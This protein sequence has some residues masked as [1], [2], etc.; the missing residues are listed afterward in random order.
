MPPLN[1]ALALAQADHV[2][3]LVRQYL[4]LDVARALDELLHVEIAVAECRRRL[5]LRRLEHV[6]QL[7]LR[8]DD[9]H[10]ASAA[11]RRGLDD[12]RETD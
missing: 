8:A 3:M 9:A 6:R 12:H 2:A 5:A 10:A 4:E 11:A 1:T 7:F